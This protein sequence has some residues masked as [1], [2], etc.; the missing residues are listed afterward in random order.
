VEDDEGVAILQRRALERRGFTVATAM[1]LADAFAAVRDNLAFDLIVTDY[2][3]N[4]DSGLEL[5][6]KIHALGRDAPPVIVVTGFSDESTAIEAIRCGARDFVP[7]SAEYL[8]YLPDAVERVLKAVRTERKLAQ[9]E[10]QFQLFMDNSPAIA[11]IKDEQGRLLYANS[12]TRR[13]LPCED[14]QGKSNFELWPAEFAKQIHANDLAA[15]QGDQLVHCRESLVTPDGALRHFESYKFPMREAS[16]RR[17]L[18]GMA[19]EVTQQMAAEQ[20]LRERDE[21]LRH[22]Q[23]MEAV[24]TLAGGVAH[25]FNNLLQAIL[26]YIKFGME[27]LAADDPRCQD[28]QQALSAADRATVL[29]RQLL[30]FG[31]RQTLELKSLDANQLITDMVKLLRPL[32][33]ANISV[34]LGLSQ[35]IGAIHADAG[36]FQQLLMNLCINARDAMPEGGTLLIKTEDLTLSPRYCEVHP[37]V[38]PGRYLAITVSDTGIGMTRDVVE[39]IFEPFF[40]TKE[41]GK[42]TGLGLAMVYGMVQQH[43]GVIRVYSEPGIGTTFKI[44]LPTSE[45][46]AGAEPQDVVAPPRGGAE[47]I[48]IAEDEV[49]VQKL[50]DRILGRAGYRLLTASDGQQAWEMFQAHSH[51]IDLLVLDVVMPHQSGREVYRRIEKAR[52]GMPVVFCSGYDPDAAHIKVDNN[53][54]R[55]LQKPFDPDA[56]LQTVRE[57]LDRESLCLTS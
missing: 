49:L 16:G 43:Q 29:T 23:K 17:L 22:S 4:G 13:L 6:T 21:Q 2:R 48:L 20:A 10:A 19:V 52:P 8:H 31:R 54:H 55:F 38:T 25:E 28:L 44:Y 41:I 9:S 56:L 7:K 53:G 30:G 47:T 37:D 34:E 11:F 50:Y 3:L 46:S 40:T 1:N 36:H 45:K 26:A 57:V 18:G 42:G 33:G 24:G 12:A 35:D 5:L 27:G 32:I 51:E 39:H 15:L 14:W